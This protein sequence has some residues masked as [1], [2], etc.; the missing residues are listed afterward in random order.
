[1]KKLLI[2][3][4]LLTGIW[5][6]GC[7]GSTERTPGTVEFIEVCNDHRTLTEY[8]CEA[9]ILSIEDELKLRQANNTLDST[10]QAS[11]T[12]LT[13]RLRMMSRQSVSI[14]KFANISKADAKLIAEMVENRW[15]NKH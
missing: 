8:T 2:G 7:G 11:L 15:K 1:M 13:E 9:L 12:N 10:T 14:S 3:F 5:T 4:V 6:T